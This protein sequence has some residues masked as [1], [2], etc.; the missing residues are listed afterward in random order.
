MTELNELVVVEKA[1]VPALFAKDGCDPLLKRIKEE[2]GKF[3]ADISTA[4]GRKEVASMASKVAKS[5]VYLE[6]L[7]KDLVTGI[8]EQAKVIDAERKKVR[9]ELDLLKEEVRKPLTDWENAEKKRV[10]DIE[11][12]IH[13][14]EDFIDVQL[15]LSATS[16]DV[17]DAINKINAIIVDES[18][19]EFELA[20]T[21]AKANAVIQLEAKFI[22]LQ[23]AEKE[24][25]EAERL[26]KERSEKEREDREKKIAE[27]AAEAAK[28]EAEDKAKAEA[29]EKDRL[30]KEAIEKAERETLEAKLA[31]ERAEREKKEAAELA[32]KEKE[33]AIEEERKRVAAVKESERIAEEKLAQNKAHRGKLNKEAKQSFIDEG[34]DAEE[35]ERIIKVIAK[36]RIANI[37]INY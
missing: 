8:K 11:E 17:K 12:R 29:G 1:N 20:A 16:A 22:V 34:F 4:K 36:G 5:K 33:A 10:A 28:K 37:T 2:V 23:N 3:E 9:D 30:A 21:K 18:F 15:V 32:E 7:G 25:A 26:D 19:E 35:A 31:T 27:E 6:G 13:T 24:K 14:I